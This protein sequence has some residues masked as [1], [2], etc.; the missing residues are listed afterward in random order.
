MRAAHTGS[1]SKS[2]MPSIRQ[3]TT[4]R[5]S[6][7]WRTVSADHFMLRGLEGEW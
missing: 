1:V 6:P 2:P 7:P 5:R 3:P 4:M